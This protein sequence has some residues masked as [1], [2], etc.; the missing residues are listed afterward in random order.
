MEIRFL[1]TGGAFNFEKGT[2]AATVAMA[3][4]TILIDCGFSTILSLAKQDVAKNIDYI[5]ITHLH[6]DH[7]GS[8]P[9]LLPY[10]QY[11]LDQ[12]IPKI[13]VPTESFTQELDRFLE[14]TY[15]ADR[16]EYVPIDQFS[17]IGYID[18]SD[19]H[20]TGMT[21]FAYYFTEGDHLIYYSGDIANADTAA[22]FL[23]NRTESRIQVFHETTP[24]TNIAVHTP[25]REIEE[26]LGSY[27]VHLYHVAKEDLPPECT[28]P[29]VEDQPDFL[30]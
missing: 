7:V 5:L 30:W 22:T 29:L 21:S 25:F 28:L 4:K 23:Q 24:H 17:D 3:D 9:T 18:T 13:I 15:E 11:V 20:V 26:K 6:G 14:A 8:L 19:Q 1:G 12:P 2:A 10:Y 16:A 27:E